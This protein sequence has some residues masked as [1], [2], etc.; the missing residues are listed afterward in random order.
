MNIHFLY[1]WSVDCEYCGLHYLKNSQAGTVALDS[2]ISKITIR[3]GFRIQHF[4]ESQS[5]S[6]SK[7]QKVTIHNPDPER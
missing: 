4:I 7:A 1:S 6:V 2:D 5:G 3:F